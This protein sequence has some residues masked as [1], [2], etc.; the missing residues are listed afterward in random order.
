MGRFSALGDLLGSVFERGS[1]TFSA[2]GAV[3]ES[4]LEAMAAELISS[5]GEASGVAL[6]TRLLGGY[7]GLDSDGRRAFFRHLAEAWEPDAERALAA[8]SAY[9]DDPTPERQA[10]LAE[11]LEPRRQELFRRLN[12]APGG[13]AALVRMRADLLRAC[14]DEPDL[15]RIDRDFRQLLASWFNRGFLVLR[16]I[17]WQTPAAVLEKIIAYE[18][19]H[20]IDSWE[21]LRRRVVPPDRRCF[22]F[23]HPSMPDEPLIFVE[24]ALVRE[25]PG[26][27]QALLAADRAGL[28]PAEATVA[29]FYSISNCQPGLA[30]VSFGAFLIKQVAEDLAHEIPSLSTYVTLSPVPG[31]MR[32]LKE[33]AED[34]PDGD[35]AEVL[36]TL[37]HLDWS[38]GDAITA[39]RPRVLSLAARYLLD[40]KRSD[41]KPGDPVARFHLGNGAELAAMH[42][43]GDTAPNG[44]R[45]GAG[46]MVNYR[47]RLDR[48]EAN[49]EA[50]ASE[51]RIATTRAVRALKG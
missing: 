25:I 15:K 44:V 48:I 34:A 19:V 30:G 20:Q 31:L 7:A 35:A 22:A 27:I 50:Y 23:F 47:Y 33:E 40:A 37:D 17:D 32:W 4:A 21:E 38:S 14:R 36:A 49:H 3:P 18:A 29:V 13:T 28:A 2:N 51:G 16:P 45:T 8:A 43:P 11:A 24:V 1:W 5:K 41:G 12:H 39:A 9:G 10:A 46:V 6:A 42:W 26:S